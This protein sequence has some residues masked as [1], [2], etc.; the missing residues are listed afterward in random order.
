MSTANADTKILPVKPAVGLVVVSLI[1][2]FLA[3]LTAQECH[4]NLERGHH[5]QASF[6][7]SLAYGSA[8]WMWWIAITLVL[9]IL[10]SRW[11]T[12]LKPSMKMALG[13]LGTACTL[14]VAHLALVQYTISF[15]SLHWPAWGRLYAAY[16]AADL[17]HFGINI[18]VYGFICGVCAVLH[19]RM[20]MQQTIVQKLEVE[21]QLT[22]AQLQTLQTQME[23]HFLFN[24]LNAI[25]S[26]MVQARNK[27]AI[28]TMTHLSDI[29]RTTLQRKAHEKVLLAEELRIVESYLAIQQVRFAGR[30]EVKIDTT[31]EAM[32]G[33]V[34]CFLLQPL[35]ENAIQHGIMPKRQGGSIETRVKRVGDKLWVQV[36]DDGCGANSSSTKGHGI[37]LQNIKERLA[38]FY[39][40]CYE[41]RTA[42]PAGGGYEVTI[43]IPYER[44]M[45]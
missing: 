44:A 24:T 23:P 42:S 8:T 22:Q 16:N 35:V 27:E 1:A 9:W 43:Q 17:E 7:P 21:R 14:A 26:L 40:N 25:T 6:A 2:G 30:L 37:G 34:P 41:F 12:V 39:P 32:D 38:Y 10:A 11:P 36:K 31:D 18:V 15:A 3:V 19:S 45:A 13:H 29:L 33:L 28:R 5:L 4:H 20:Q